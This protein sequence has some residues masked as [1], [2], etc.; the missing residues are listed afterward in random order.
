MTEQEKSQHNRST[1]KQ[2]QIITTTLLYIVSILYEGAI[3][4]NILI[5]FM[6]REIKFNHKTINH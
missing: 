1:W 6:K 2:H 4:V 3:C 5:S